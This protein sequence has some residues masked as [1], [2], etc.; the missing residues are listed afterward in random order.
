[1]KRLQCRS[2]ETQP[3]SVTYPRSLLDETLAMSFNGN[4]AMERHISK[5]STR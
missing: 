5:E 2:M 1:M 4:T 3:W